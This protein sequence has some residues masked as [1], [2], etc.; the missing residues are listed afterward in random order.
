VSPCS[1]YE[2]DHGRSDEDQSGDGQATSSEETGDEYEPDGGDQVPRGSHFFMIP[3]NLPPVKGY[4]WNVAVGKVAVAG[5]G[6]E[7]R[8]ERPMR[9]TE[10][11]ET[12]CDDSARRWMAAL[13]SRSMRASNVS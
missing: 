8:R 5:H 7:G 12:S 1:E 10:Q 3:Q 11:S 6:R 9:V 13:W 2:R 4:M